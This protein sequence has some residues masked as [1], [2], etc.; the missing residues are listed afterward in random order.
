MYYLGVDL[1]SLSCDA[2]IIGE[3][4][5]VLASSVVP[6]GARNREA[7]ARAT[8]EVLAAAGVREDA[9]A[10]PGGPTLRRDARPEEDGRT[11]PRSTPGRKPGPLATGSSGPQMISR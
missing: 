11:G 5:S 1:G 8:S 2:V 9:A 7:I 4:G 10:T 3:N 6:T